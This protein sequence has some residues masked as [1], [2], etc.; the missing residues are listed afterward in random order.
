[1]ARKDYGTGWDYTHSELMEMSQEL[2]GNDYPYRC[3]RSGRNGRNV[4]VCVWD[5]TW[6][7]RVA[8]INLSPKEA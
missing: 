4:E 3:F 6:W 8:I 1:M 5:L 2:M 7:I